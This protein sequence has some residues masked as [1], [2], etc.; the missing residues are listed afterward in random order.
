MEILLVTGVA[1]FVNVHV[2]LSGHGVPVGG[3]V[4]DPKRLA[5]IADRLNPSP[6]EGAE[7]LWTDAPAHPAG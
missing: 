4:T 2:P 1:A 5:R 3:I 6:E 7:A